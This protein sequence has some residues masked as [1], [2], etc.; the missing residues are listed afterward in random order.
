MYKKFYN[1]NE[2]PFKIVPNPNFLFLSPRYENA[3]TY[4]EYGLAEKS[5]FIMLTGEIGMGKTT[6][7]RY[8]LN[9]LES[10]ME[11][12]VILNT[13]VTSDQILKLILLEFELP[14]SDVDKSKDLET[15]YRFLIEQYKIGK[16]VIL[17][18]DEAQNLTDEALEEVRMLSNLQS[19]EEILL[20]V[21]VVGQPE[22]KKRLR[23]PGLAQFS[24]RIAVSYHLSPVTRKECYD[25]I[26]HRLKAAGGSP[27]I[28]LQ[29]AMDMIYDN[30]GGIPRTINLLCD[31]CLV[32]GFAD[33]IEKIGK[34]I[35]QQVID[36]K[37]G[38][39]IFT[40]SF[41]EGTFDHS[42]SADQSTVESVPLNEPDEKRKQLP[43]Q[44]ECSED[45]KKEIQRIEGKVQ[46]LEISAEENKTVLEKKIDQVQKKIL[47]KLIRLLLAERKQNARL[48]LEYGSLKEKYRMLEKK[49]NAVIH[50]R[51]Q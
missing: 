2:K 14:T 27:D 43:L 16:Q 32:Y 13:N 42:V 5:G 49:Y 50:S 12:G 40:D 23:E 9:K 35:V 25:Y 29:D 6:L 41:R 15:L 8:L 1:L 30:S 20:Q 21:M 38:M 11:V 45:L 24:Q 36:D 22:L 3:L 17:I 39:G 34:Y 46:E 7:I 47:G 4:L 10:R 37:E 31:A 18:I 44:V 28:F 51:D 48:M 19:D 26:A 33:E